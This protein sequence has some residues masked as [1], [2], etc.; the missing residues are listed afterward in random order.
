MHALFVLANDLFVL[1]WV[2]KKFVGTC[3]VFF[4]SFCGCSVFTCSVYFHIQITFKFMTKNRPT[5]LSLLKSLWIEIWFF[6]FS[7]IWVFFGI[8]YFSFCFSFL[9]NSQCIFL[10]VRNSLNP[11]KNKIKKQ[12]NIFP[13]IQ[14]FCWKHLLLSTLQWSHN[15][16]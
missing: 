12:L 1:F 9:S 3:F 10:I 14:C 2:L 4:F 8:G 11:A 15:I 7:T 13:G 6:K 5:P 16:S